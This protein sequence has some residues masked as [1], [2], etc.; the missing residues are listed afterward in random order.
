MIRTRLLWFTSGMLVT[1]GA[2]AYYLHQDLSKDRFL[3]VNQ[4][5]D[6]FGALETR[7]STLESV[8]HNSNVQDGASSS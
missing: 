8:P 6:N 1:G 4:L 5:K 2:I 3:L 7:V